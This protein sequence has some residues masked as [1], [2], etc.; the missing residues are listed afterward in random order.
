MHVKA[1]KFLRRFI[2]DQCFLVT[3]F[4]RMWPERDI[5]GYKLRHQAVGPGGGGGGGG[6]KHRGAPH[7]S[8]S[9]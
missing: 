7:V 2:T 5:T 1:I 8:G 6:E 9:F 3:E 4:W